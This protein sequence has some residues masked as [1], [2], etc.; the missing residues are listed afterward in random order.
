M[1]MIS[2]RPKILVPKADQDVALKSLKIE[3]E[4]GFDENLAME[5]AQRCLV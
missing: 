1:I 5:E 3:V 4:K 2:L